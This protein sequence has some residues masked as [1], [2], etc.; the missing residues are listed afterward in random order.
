MDCSPS[1]VKND[2]GS[3]PSPPWEEDL[4]GGFVLRSVRDERDIERYVAL[5][6]DLFHTTDCVTIDRLLRYHPEVTYRD[7]LMVEDTVAGRIASTTCIV[8]WRFRYDE[9]ELCAAQVEVV[10]THPDYRR[11]GLLRAQMHRIHRVLLERG[12]HLS[13]IGGIPNY[14]RQFG[15]TYAI[16]QLRPV[17]VPAHAIPRAPSGDGERIRLREAAVDDA[18]RLA[19]LYARAM[20]PVALHDQRSEEFW[21]Y[22]LRWCRLP[23]QIVEDSDTGAAVGYV[24]AG[25]PGR[26]GVAHVG[27]SAIFSTD[28]AFAV[29]RRLSSPSTT[30]VAVGG[31]KTGLLRQV[32][33]TLAPAPARHPQWLLRIGDLA[34]FLRQI[35]PVLER[36]LA[37]SAFAGLSCDVR[38]NTFREAV[39]LRFQAGKLVGVDRAGFVDASLRADGGPLQF[40]ADALVR[41]ALGYRSVDQLLDAWPDIVIAPELRMLP[42]VLFPAMSSFLYLPYNYAGPVPDTAAGALSVPSS[43]SGERRAHD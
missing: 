34:G 1:T 40:P 26:A 29:L 6:F 36:R 30:A 4:G 19:Q 38:L 11:R 33:T 31:P 32:A 12:V 8:P 41:L 37:R 24:S 17:L 3:A 39:D 43:G 9:V 10:A 14:Y 42:E 20:A 2:A 15:Y 23:L 18:R 35:G 21:R 25:P 27:E 22:L 5:H 13:A 16:D 7:F 28:I